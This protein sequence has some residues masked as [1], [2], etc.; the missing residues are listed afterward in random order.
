MLHRPG[1]RGCRLARNRRQLPQR[2][3]RD[4]PSRCS[5]G[6][7]PS[8]SHRSHL[9]RRADLARRH[10]VLRR[11]ILS[12]RPWRRDR[13]LVLVGSQPPSATWASTGTDDDLP[14]RPEQRRERRPQRARR[15]RRPETPS[16]VDVSNPSAAL[17][18]RAD[19]QSALN[20]LFLASAPSRCSS[21]RSRREHH[22]H[23][24]ARTPL[25][26]RL[27]PR[28]RRNAGHIARNSSPKPSALA[29]RRAVAS[30]SAS[31]R[32]R[33]TPAPSTSRS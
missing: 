32:P 25:G 7:P 9:P 27:A 20:G 13:Q 6:R 33:S 30:D 23:L 31:S 1:C 5:A 4:E 15:D 10:V 2:G 17:Q 18:A 19:A 16:N 12:R 21:A 11:R 29:R 8:S 26:D 22:G 24:G 3:N 28:A 14:A